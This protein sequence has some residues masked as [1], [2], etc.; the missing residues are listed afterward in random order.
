MITVTDVIISKPSFSTQLTS[1]KNCLLGVKIVSLAAAVSA[2]S[3]LQM[4]SGFAFGCGMALTAS[5]LTLFSEKVIRP[6]NP[7]FTSSNWINTEINKAELN[8]FIYK[9]L[10]Y[11]TLFTTIVFGRIFSP[12]QAVACAIQAMNLKLVLLATVI[13]PVTEE[14][15]FRGFLQERIEDILIVTNHF[16]IEIKTEKIKLLASYTSSFLFGAAHIVGNQVV[17]LASKIAILALITFR[18]KFLSNQKNQNNG[19]LLPS[20]AAHMA[21]NTSFTCGLILAKRLFH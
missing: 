19:S 14:I 4:G 8:E 2:F 13:A 21:H 20:I 10:I 7:E 18:G 3:V 9:R 11:G 1:N 6:L 5:T 16:V 12:L 15:L 17:S